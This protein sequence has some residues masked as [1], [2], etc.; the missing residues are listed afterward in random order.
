MTQSERQTQQRSI[1]A[2]FERIAPHYDFV[3]RLISMGQDQ[4]L[5]RR[6]L[7]LAQLPP[8]GL[9]LDVG[10]GTGDVALNAH[11]R[12]PNCCVVGLD[13]TAAMLAWAQQ[14]SQG[15]PPHWTRG[16]GL[17]LPYLD[18]SF[19]TV[20]SAFL[21]RNVPDVTTALAEQARVVRPGGRVICLEMSW[22]G[23]FPM[24]Q[25]F[26]VYFFGWVPLI[27]QLFT[28]ERTAYT[29]LPKSVKAFA[30]PQTLAQ[31]MQEAGLTEIHWERHVLGTT[32]ILS[33]QKPE[34]S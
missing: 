24:A 19:D 12:C 3:N 14:K 1:R 9:L 34:T 16:D 32:A 28:G 23:H 8:D 21:L 5:R 29:Y 25:L 10:T 17:A 4:R 22:P 27:G 2:L 30:R 33:G 20:I 26:Y 11:A 6:A 15:R 7:R 31:H 18:D 13:P